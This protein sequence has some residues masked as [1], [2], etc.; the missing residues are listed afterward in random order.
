M[1]R[2]TGSLLHGDVAAAFAYN[3]Y[4][5]AVFAQGILFGLW[6]YKNNNRPMTSTQQKRLIV[7]LAGNSVVLLVVWGLRLATG[8]IDGVY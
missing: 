8:H 6:W 3:P 7:M 4:A 5:L 2:A 1:S